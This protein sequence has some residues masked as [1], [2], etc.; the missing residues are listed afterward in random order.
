MHD[1][2]AMSPMIESGAHDRHVR[3]TGMCAR[4]SCARDKG[5]MSRQTWTMT[6]VPI[7]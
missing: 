4:Q 1:R 7:S 6:E 3:A 5:I 2:D